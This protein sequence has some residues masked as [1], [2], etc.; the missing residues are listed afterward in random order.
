MGSVT[1]IVT[2]G[3]DRNCYVCKMGEEIVQV[4]VMVEKRDNLGM[5]RVK[6]ME[7]EGIYTLIVRGRNM[8]CSKKFIQSSDV[9]L[10]MFMTLKPG[11]SIPSLPKFISR[12]IML[13]LVEIVDK[14]ITDIDSF[15]GQVSFIYLLNTVQAVD[16]L[17]CFD[18][19]PK[20]EKTRA[21]VKVT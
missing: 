9:L 6:E 10:F 5:E 1:E 15:F 17:D 7:N 11:D 13:D 20:L 21:A 14:K 16:F 12:Q 3:M 2:L 18:I 4:G 19:Q 8:F